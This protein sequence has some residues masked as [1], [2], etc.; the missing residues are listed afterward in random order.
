M[1][2]TAVK[3]LIPGTTLNVH[4]EDYAKSI[5]AKTEHAVIPNSTHPF[6]EDGAMGR[7]FKWTAGWIKKR[8]G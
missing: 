8:A 3:V 1:K 5:V 4:G 6:I 2:E 7:L